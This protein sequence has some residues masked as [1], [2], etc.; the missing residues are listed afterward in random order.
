VCTGFSI[1]VAKQSHAALHKHT[2]DGSADASNVPSDIS[3]QASEGS[4]DDPMSP[5]SQGSSDEHEGGLPIVRNLFDG[6]CQWQAKPSF[7]NYCRYQQ[8]KL[9]ISVMD[10]ADINNSF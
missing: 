2:S 10:I 3:E 7:N 8:F 6:C 5:R 9:W 1:S 4:E